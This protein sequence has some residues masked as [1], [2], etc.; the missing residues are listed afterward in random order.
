MLQFLRVL[1]RLYLLPIKMPAEEE[2]EEEEEEE[3]AVEEEA[4]AEEEMVVQKQVMQAHLQRW[5]LTQQLWW[6]VPQASCRIS[7]VKKLKAKMQRGQATKP[8]AS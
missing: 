2:V 6:S 5:K 3:V 7:W 8:N 4:V 1:V